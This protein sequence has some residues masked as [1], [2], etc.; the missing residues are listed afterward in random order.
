MRLGG[1]SVGVSGSTLFLFAGRTMP[2]SISSLPIPSALWKRLA[3]RHSLSPQQTRIVELILLNK[4]DKQIA[5][6]M[7]LKV[8]TVR[9]YLQRVFLRMGVNDR[10][11]LVL[12]LF[13]EC[14]Q[15][16]P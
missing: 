9:T 6:A 5:Q 11:S 14:M 7:G 12:K 4:C 2:N 15:Q 8:P 16:R 3:T 10:L 1:R 13:A